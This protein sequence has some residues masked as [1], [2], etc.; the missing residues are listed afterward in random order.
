MYKI[1]AVFYLN[2]A[3]KR[4]TI[5]FTEKEILAAKD[6]LEM[7]SSIPPIDCRL[8]R[9]ILGI[10]ETRGYGTPQRT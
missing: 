4:I 7:Q 5:L 10:A 8:L 9:Q 6:F 1:I 2:I 3:A